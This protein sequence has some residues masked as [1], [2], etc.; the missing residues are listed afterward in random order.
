MRRFNTTTKRV[1]VKLDGNEKFAE[2]TDLQQPTKLAKLTDNKAK[3][4]VLE[5]GSHG[6]QAISLRMHYLIVNESTLR[7]FFHIC[8]LV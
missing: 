2:R 3:L 6:R 5:L 7:L 8:V 1:S 4:H